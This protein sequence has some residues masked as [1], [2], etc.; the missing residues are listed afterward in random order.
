MRYQ[1][2][3]T[4]RDGFWPTPLAAALV[5]GLGLASALAAQEPPPESPCTDGLPF[6]EAL[7]NETPLPSLDVVTEGCASFEEPTVSFMVGH[8]GQTYYFAIEQS[9]GCAEAD[10]KL[11]RWVACWTWEPALC[12]SDPE[13]SMVET[14]VEWNGGESGSEP[15]CDRGD[16]E[17]PGEGQD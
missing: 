15:P 14:A 11:R 12:G 6:T 1:E 9:S 10:D 2:A 8:D 16:S 13:L 17:P 4:R 5:L 7:P 3:I